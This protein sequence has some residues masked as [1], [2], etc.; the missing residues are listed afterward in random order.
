MNLSGS[1]I[2]VG[3]AWFVLGVAGVGLNFVGAWLWLGLGRA[4]F[5]SGLLV[6]ALAW[7]SIAL[8]M[9]LALRWSSNVQ[10][11]T[12]ARKGRGRRDA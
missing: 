7:C 11:M 8:F 12:K 9:V 10:T 1:N 3:R 2:S 6:V 4:L 5:I